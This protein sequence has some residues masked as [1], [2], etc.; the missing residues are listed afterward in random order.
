VHGLNL[1]LLMFFVFYVV[2][3][4]TLFFLS[5]L[6]IDLDDLYFFSYVT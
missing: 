5:I 6:I 4:I 2:S 3:Y 1:D